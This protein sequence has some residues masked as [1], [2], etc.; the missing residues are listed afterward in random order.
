M[1]CVYASAIVDDS[2]K[3]SDSNPTGDP[4]TK[5]CLFRLKEGLASFGFLY[6]FDNG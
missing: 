5:S 4:R 1:T 2:L 3:A 6:H